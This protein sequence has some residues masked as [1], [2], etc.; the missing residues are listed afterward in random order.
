MET[1]H[2][3]SF[4]T[5]A[6]YGVQGTPFGLSDHPTR[7]GVGVPWH[8]HILVKNN[9]IVSM[10]Y[11]GVLISPSMAIT[12]ARESIHEG[13]NKFHIFPYNRY[14]ATVGTSNLGDPFTPDDDNEN[15]IIPINVSGLIYLF[16]VHQTIKLQFCKSNLISHQNG[17]PNNA[18]VTS[19]CPSPISILVHL[20]CSF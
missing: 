11:P 18:G 4:L 20:L 2:I 17:A 19:W 15:G 16:A 10:T 3:S 14:H 6:L 1:F 5:I 12:R 7:H 13:G 9:D 8:V